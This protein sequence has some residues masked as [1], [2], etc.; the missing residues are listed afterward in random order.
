[1]L[2]F[3]KKEMP[4]ENELAEEYLIVWEKYNYNLIH[5][6]E[7]YKT[8]NDLAKK[9]LSINH[10]ITKNANFLEI[11]KKIIFKEIKTLWWLA[12]KIAIYEPDF[13]KK[14]YLHWYKSD[15]KK[16]FTWEFILD[17]WEESINEWQKDKK[18]IL[19]NY[20]QWKEKNKEE[21]DQIIKQISDFVFKS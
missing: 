9:L 2:N 7:D 1:M 19:E 21:Y 8:T 17:N 12:L 11:Y 6:S 5:K 20:F 10:R 4:S 3:L 15:K 18:N 14:L 13:W 16:N